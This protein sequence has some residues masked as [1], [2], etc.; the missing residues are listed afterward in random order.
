MI[1][2]V[3]AGVA[4]TSIVVALA[5]CGREPAKTAKSD[6][7]LPPAVMDP[8]VKI[9]S[10][11]EVPA[12]PIV[13]AAA[14]PSKFPDFG[15]V[16]LIK[17]GVKFREATLERGKAPMRIWFYEPE[18]AADKLA[19]VLVP[20]AGST[21]YIGMELAEGDR[22]EHYPYAEAGFAVA[23]FDI[24]GHVP[25]LQFAGDDAVLQGARAF[26]ES[27]AGLANAKAALEFVLAKAPQIEPKRINLS[28]TRAP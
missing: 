26:R 24:D 20:P 19:L 22:T 15:P 21:L 13:V 25:N 14:D 27:Q 18:N 11:A 17:P 10:P 1:I 6:K 16:Q 7:A 12:P 3:F 8:P 2:R 23:S 4:I 28:R 9:E 5:G